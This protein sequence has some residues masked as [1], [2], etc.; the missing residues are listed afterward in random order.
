MAVQCIRNS[1]PS[2]GGSQPAQLG[3]TWKKPKSFG[4]AENRALTEQPV[5]QV[6]K[7]QGSRLVHC[8]HSCPGWHSCGIP[9]NRCS[10]LFSEWLQWALSHLPSKWHC[11]AV[12]DSSMEVSPYSGI[13]FK[14][15]ARDSIP[16][17]ADCCDWLLSQE[18]SSNFNYIKDSINQICCSQ[19]YPPAVCVHAGMCTCL[20]KGCCPACTLLLCKS[21]PVPTVHNAGWVFFFLKELL[22]LAKKE[23]AQRQS[24]VQSSFHAGA[25]WGAALLSLEEGRMVRDVYKTAAWK[26]KREMTGHCL[27][28]CLNWKWADEVIRYKTDKRNSLSCKNP[29]VEN[30]VWQPD[31]RWPLLCKAAMQTKLTLV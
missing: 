29:F 7:E 26:S 10:S 5:Q 14:R 24:E 27:C 19:F 31:P 20:L 9:C 11:M 1:R 18:L 15:K 16:E 25:P 17:R 30:P 22:N 2:K 12:T 6:D 8:Q 13:V 3:P 28:Q 23:K 21:L 4:K